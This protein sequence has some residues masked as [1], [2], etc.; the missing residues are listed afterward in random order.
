M[1]VDAR[2]LIWLSPAFPV[3]AFAYSHGLE[4]AAERGWVVGREGLE[5]W[6]GDLVAC[7]SLRNDLILLA[8]AWRAGTDGNQ[9]GVSAVNDLALAL[10]P[11]AERRL[12]AVGQGQAFLAAIQ[13]A[14]EPDGT[15]RRAR[16]DG[17]AAY[18]VAVGATAGRHG[19]ELDGTLLAYAIQFATNLVS[20]GIRLSLIGQTDGQRILAAML[21]ALKAVAYA[22]ARTTLDDLGGATLRSDL[23]SLA[24]ETQYSR[25]FRS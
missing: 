9:D 20:A 12:E 25:L 22:A 5:A 14:W 21:P 6:I 4:L 2:L 3:G 17:E 10:Q 15:A 13:A 23:A 8:E 24:H 16:C 11:S 1:E 19:I 18:A 7:G